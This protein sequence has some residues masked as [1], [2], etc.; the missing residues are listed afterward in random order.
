M[1]DKWF[2]PLQKEIKVWLD[3]HEYYHWIWNYQ[4]ILKNVVY[5]GCT[6]WYKDKDGCSHAESLLFRMKQQSNDF[7]IFKLL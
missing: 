3:S 7:V 1:E 6:A 5:E 4:D 2:Y